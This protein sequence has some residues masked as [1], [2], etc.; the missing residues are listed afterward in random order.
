MILGN[1]LT[2]DIFFPVTLFFTTL[3]SILFNFVVIRMNI[4]P[5]LKIALLVNSFALLIFL[6][7]ILCIFGTL[8]NLQKDSLRRMKNIVTT[9]TELR[10]IGSLRIEKTLIGSFGA[11]EPHLAFFI[12]YSVLNYTTTH[13]ILFK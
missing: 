13:L 12:V 11:I 4:V 8:F 9:K 7:V 2:R 5:S 6:C 3:V 1:E 10:L